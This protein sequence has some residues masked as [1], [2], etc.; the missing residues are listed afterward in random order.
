M[1][2]VRLFW[3]KFGAGREG[4]DSGTSEDIEVCGESRSRGSKR[5]EGYRSWRHVEKE[6]LQD[7][8]NGLEG[9]G[10]CLSISEVGTV[11]NEHNI[12]YSPCDWIANRASLMDFQNINEE[13][14]LF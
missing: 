11:P 1:M 12:V 4:P 10:Q 5:I 9:S 13:S 14:D 2:R 6:K 8:L 7:V 3:S